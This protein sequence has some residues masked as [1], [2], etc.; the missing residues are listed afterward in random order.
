MIEYE[1]WNFGNEAFTKF[2]NSDT[3]K[4]SKDNM[5]YCEE[6]LK[7]KN[8]IVNNDLKH[9]NVIAYKKDLVNN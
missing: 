3:K 5:I 6:M 4:Y 2:F 7:Y 9:D 8:Y 1:K